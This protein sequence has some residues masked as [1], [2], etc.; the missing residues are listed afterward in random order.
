MICSKYLQ[1][2]V[3][4]NLSII[5][6]STWF[7]KAGLTAV[8]PISSDMFEVFVDF[9]RAPIPSIGVRISGATVPNF[10][11]IFPGKLAQLVFPW[12]LICC[13]AL[14]ALAQITC[15]IIIVSYIFSEKETKIIAQTYIRKF[16]VHNLSL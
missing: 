11:V 10:V 15:K 6:S 8:A 16:Q 13:T 2:T 4:K 3:Q 1:C 14:I 9:G 5:F 7:V 12:T